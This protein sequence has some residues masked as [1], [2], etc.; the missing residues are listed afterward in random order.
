VGG[1]EEPLQ[2]SLFR[3]SADTIGKVFHYKV[4]GDTQSFEELFIGGCVKKDELYHFNSLQI[5]ARRHLID[6]LT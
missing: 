6:G 3:A 2:G 1:G 5:A 4:L